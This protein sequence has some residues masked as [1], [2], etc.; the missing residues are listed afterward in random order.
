MSRLILYALLIAPLAVGCRRESGQDAGRKNVQ[1]L[2]EKQLEQLNASS[3]LTL[4]DV[5][6]RLREG[7]PIE[8]FDRFVAERN[9]G[10]NESTKVMGHALVEGDPPKV[11]PNKQVRIYYLRDA[12]LIVVTESVGTGSPAKEQ[13]VSWR[14]EPPR[15]RV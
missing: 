9:K 5:K 11:I 2:M 10:P 4:A 1:K 3:P 8:D 6:D 12:N 15:S 7:M 14:T 13:V